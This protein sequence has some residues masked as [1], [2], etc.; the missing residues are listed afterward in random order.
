[1]SGGEK[2]GPGRKLTITEK[3]VRASVLHNPLKLKCIQSMNK[4]QAHFSV[5]Q[6]ALSLFCC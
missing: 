6:E 3:E 2:R 1:M 5:P 4:P